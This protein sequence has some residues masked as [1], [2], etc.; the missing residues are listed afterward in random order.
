MS[1]FT[2]NDNAGALVQ[3]FLAAPPAGM[4]A[5]VAHGP[6]LQDGVL[7]KM[8]DGTLEI[9]RS[10]TRQEI[11]TLSYLEPEARTN[12]RCLA[13]KMAAE[14]KEESP[15]LSTSSIV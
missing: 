12:G 9:G 15:C 6:D 2:N 13:N 4:S 8:S 14:L 3:S 11:N 5:T 7:L 10:L 1:P